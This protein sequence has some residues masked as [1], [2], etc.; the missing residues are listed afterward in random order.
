MKPLISA[1]FFLYMVLFLQVVR[2]FIVVHSTSD[3]LIERSFTVVL[4]TYL[5]FFFQE[6][7]NNDFGGNR[8]PDLFCLFLK[9]K[10]LSHSVSAD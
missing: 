6:K 1:W 7:R 5:P 3:P 10:P 9:D 8:T 2:S 4:S